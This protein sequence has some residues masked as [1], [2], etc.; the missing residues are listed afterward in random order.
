LDRGGIHRG[1]E[2]HRLPPE[3]EV[4]PHRRPLVGP[5]LLDLEAELVAVERDALLHVL[6]GQADGHLLAVFGRHGFLLEATRVGWE[7]R[8]AG[9]AYPIR[10]N[11]AAGYGPRAR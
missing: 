9:R 1:P 11:A 2:H 6:A 3:H 4:A 8:G 7:R 5:A 10:A